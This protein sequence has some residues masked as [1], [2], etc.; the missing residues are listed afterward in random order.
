MS[1]PG[2]ARPFPCTLGPPRDERTNPYEINVS[3]PPINSNIAG[4]FHGVRRSITR[5][6]LLTTA[7]VDIGPGQHGRRRRWRGGEG[8]QHGRPRRLASTETSTTFVHACCKPADTLELE[9]QLLLLLLLQLQL[10][11][12]TISSGPS[13][14]SAQALVDQ[15]NR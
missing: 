9:G 11:P 5:R 14:P 13:S 3:H 10:L 6:S 8:E 4:S 15:I 12:E 2:P 1:F 7:V